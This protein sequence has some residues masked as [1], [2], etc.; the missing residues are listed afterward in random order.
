MKRTE[1]KRILSA[2]LCLALM[3]GCL[4]G[5][6]IATTAADG[7]GEVIYEQD[8]DGLTELPE[9]WEVIRQ[10]VT[11][12]NVTV[13]DG[14]LCINAK[15]ASN[16]NP[17]GA[18]YMGDEVKVN[19]FTLEMDYTPVEEV[20]PQ[21]WTSLMYNIQSGKSGTSYSPYYHFA[22][23]RGASAPDAVEL[24][25]YNG[26]WDYVTRTS[27][28]ADMVLGETYH[29]KVVVVGNRVL[30]YLDDQLMIDEEISGHTWYANGGGIGVQT[31]S[32]NILIDNFK[33]TKTNKID[34]PQ[35][36]G[37]ASVYEPQ[38][39][40]KMAP[41]VVQKE[42]SQEDYDA[43]KT[44][45]VRPA[46][47]VFTL[48][49]ALDVL[50]ADGSKIA[51]LS[52]ALD[53]LG[54]A[55]I[56]GFFVKDEATVQALAAQI[57]PD[58]QDATVFSDDNAVLDIA[59]HTLKRVR[60]AYVPVLTGDI[61]PDVL[62]ELVATGNTSFSKILVIDGNKITKDQVLY[63][64]CRL[65]TV[66]LTTTGTGADSAAQMMKGADGLVSDSYEGSIA[67]I[68]SFKDDTHGIVRSP[69]TIAHRGWSANYPENTMSAFKAA[70]EAGA[71]M[72]ETDFH[73]TK[74]GVLVLMHDD[75]V[76][77]TTDGK[78]AI[79]SKTYAEL[80]ELHIKNADGTL[81]DEKIPTMEELFQYLQDKDTVAVMEIKNSNPESLPKF[82]DM[83]KKYHME[84]R[85]LAPSFILSQIQ[86]M[87]RDYPE[88]GVGYF[89]Y[90][91]GA[92]TAGDKLLSI[93]SSMEANEYTMHTQKENVNSELF[94]LAKHRGVV[95]HN[96]TYNT[97][98]EV[99]VSLRQGVQSL[100][101]NGATWLDGQYSYLVPDDPTITLQQNTPV[102]IEATAVC[103][104]GGK[105]G[106]VHVGLVNV[107][108]SDIT[109]S[110]TKSGKVY[111]DKQGTVHAVMKYEVEQ[112]DGTYTVYS[113]PVT[114][115]ITAGTTTEPEPEP[116]DSSS[117]EPTTTAP[118][119][120]DEV[121]EGV[122]K[123]VNLQANNPDA[124]WVKD[125]KIGV[126]KDVP[127]AYAKYP[128]ISIAKDEEGNLVIMRTPYSGAMYVKCYAPINKTVNI[129]DNMFFYDFTAE[130]NWNLSLEVGGG[131]NIN[132]MGYIEK[133]HA[134]VNENFNLSYTEYVTDGDPGTFKGTLDLTKVIED[135]LKIKNNG[136]P[137]LAT[138]PAPDGNLTV[139]KMIIWTVNGRENLDKITIRDLYIGRPGDPNNTEPS[140]GPT[141]ENPGTGD[142]NKD[143]VLDI[144]DS[145]AL[146]SAVCGRGKISD[147]P[148]EAADI[149]GDHQINMADAYLLYLLVSG[150]PDHS[151]P[152]TPGEPSSP[153]TE[154]TE[155]TPSESTDILGAF[156]VAR[157]TVHTPGNIA[158]AVRN[159][160]G[161]ITLTID[162]ESVERW[163]ALDY[164]V[165]IPVDLSRTPYL[166][167][168]GYGA[169]NG[170]GNAML[171]LDVNGITKEVQASELAGMRKDAGQ[172]SYDLK[173]DMRG[174]LESELQ[175]ETTLTV[176]KLILQVSTSTSPNPEDSFTF[177]ELAFTA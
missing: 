75:T 41:T 1:G 140:T 76:D 32:M 25:H 78:G 170:N 97:L 153:P 58:Y 8:F 108:G 158:H 64:Q 65:M 61:T 177:R 143:G 125:Q 18:V 54:D 144:N 141:V 129:K 26:D 60:T 57:G 21:R 123:E 89:G 4:P 33:M 139:T 98:T 12:G 162:P 172:K 50:A 27:A 148:Q 152:S 174:Y 106:R 121:T 69:V 37:L 131:R 103:Q 105:T 16:T 113:A 95:F 59:H 42:D 22:I 165:T 175:T 31:S 128:E 83:V 79:A 118:Y 66:W 40:I 72:I 93:L 74:D 167:I 150:L 114:V 171:L 117:T 24:T 11:G 159:E 19:G 137:V 124:W 88:I 7:D 51:P 169:E 122:I 73:L 91:G 44:D 84:N 6:A 45:G 70:V 101:S 160:D 85:V 100:T 132:L 163:P 168:S 34:V 90:T 71:T 134:G 82:M 36:K 116:D 17:M 15:T 161:S 138:D 80:Q 23:R 115:E 35:P 46:T 127:Y 96:W 39:G 20:N 166:R 43:L 176:K 136:S 155:P 92:G 145:L 63:L 164:D 28:P 130:N 47:A 156:E 112:Y 10:N 99:N 38:T 119:I 53:R 81:S 151:A 173:V 146:Y 109:F 147:L 30:E 55:I 104:E 56:P 149:N 142:T 107:D 52:E 154:P 3:I 126:Q 13:Q 67:M 49:S 14:K 94:E 135:A 120:E 29:M 111:A 5:A 9:G 2:L 157:G 133:Q 102:E 68:E 110:N 86:V 62:D 48:N 77:R 87:R